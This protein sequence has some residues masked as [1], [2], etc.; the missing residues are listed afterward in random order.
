VRVVVGED[1]LL[2]REGI[3]RVLE[4]KGHEVVAVS[5]TLPELMKSVRTSL[6]DVVVADIRMPPSYTDEGIVAASTIRREFGDMGVLLLSQHV[7]VDYVVELLGGGEGGLGYLLKDR[8]LRPEFLSDALTRVGQG[9]CV[10]DP[11]LAD[12]LVRNSRERD[13]LD[14]LTP[15]ERQV[16]ALVAEGRTNAGIAESLVLSERTV[17]IHVK[18]VFRKLGIPD[19]PGVNR[20]VLAVLAYLR[21]A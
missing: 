6:P 10:V 16:L 12:E 2:T 14:V 21:A 7:E 4:S 11:S 20:R 5:G 9:Q 18:Q 15:R 13:P 1:Q 19:D 3:V 8:V 17:E